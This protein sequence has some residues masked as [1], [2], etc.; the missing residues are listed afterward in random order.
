MKK[1]NFDVRIE[2]KNTN[3]IKFDSAIER[4]KPESALSLWVA[5]MDFETAPEIKQALVERAS[6]GIYGYSHASSDYRK[7]LVEWMDRRHKWKT[8]QDWYV[9]TPGVVFALCTAV[10]AYTN[11]GDGI[12]I[13]RPVYYPFSHAIL[14]NDRKLINNP[15]QYEDKKYIMNTEHFE[16]C[17]IENNVKMFILCNPHNPVGRVWTKEELEIIGDICVKHNVIV[18]S[19]EIH[20]DFI[21]PGHIHTVFASIKPEYNDITVTCASPS[22]SFNLAG[23]QISN[24]VISNKKLRDKFKKQIRMSGYDEPTLFG[25]I[26]CQAAYEQGE[27]WLEELKAYLEENLCFVK[28]FLKEKLPK[29]KLVEPEGTY[30]IWLDFREYGLKEEELEDVILHKAGLWLDGGT[31]FGE[32]GDGFQRVNIATTKAYLEEAMLALEKGLSTLNCQD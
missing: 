18:I 3:C 6:H 13:Q 20:E 26:A 7:V 16:T 17:I 12:L 15:L 31:M 2:R 9:L 27:E 28:S 30:L 32:E 23:L 21:R 4:G 19:D 11:P 5:D 14:E 8:E 22:K 25:T 1:Y 29:V 24:I 10:N